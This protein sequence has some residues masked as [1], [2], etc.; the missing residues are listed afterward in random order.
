MAEFYKLSH[1]PLPVRTKAQH[2]ALHKDKGFIVT[3]AAGGLGSAIVRRL[4]AEGA[5][6]AAWDVRKEALDGLRDQLPSA[7]MRV[8]VCDLSD[9][10]AIQQAF[11]ATVSF[12]GRLDGAVNN[13][14]VVRRAPSPLDASWLDWEIT[15]AVNVYA[16]YEIARLACK[17]MIK[18]K[19]PGA[20]VNV[21]SEA[22]KKGHIQS[23]TYSASKAM[24]IN[25]TRVMSAAVAPYDINVNCVCPGSM[26]TEMLQ[27]AA[28]TIAKLTN[29]TADN[30]YPQLVSSQ[31]KRHVQPDEV[32]ATISFLLS[33]DAIAIRGQAINTDGGD[34]PY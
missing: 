32:A 9:Q 13:A 23:L 12:L 22:G 17:Q 24:L 2:F 10:E 18:E 29:S 34:T 25:M 20:I 19:T 3:G 21:A 33:D 7:E 26:A 1:D 5:R 14:A 28:A 4:L 8:F 27:R 16:P 30:V 31:L 11:E 15:S 6:V